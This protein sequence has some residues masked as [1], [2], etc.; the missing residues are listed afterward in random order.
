[1]LETGRLLRQKN[2]SCIT[3][4]KENLVSFYWSLN[5]GDI[6]DNGIGNVRRDVFNVLNNP[7][8]EILI[9]WT[10]ILDEMQKDFETFRE[11]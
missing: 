11:L 7:T 4:L 8:D 10:D 3:N 1:M 6:S 5:Y 2:G 9:D